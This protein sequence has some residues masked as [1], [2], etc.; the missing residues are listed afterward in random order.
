MGVHLLLCSSLLS[1]TLPSYFGNFILSPELFRVEKQ[2]TNE[3]MSSGKKQESIS[4]VSLASLKDP[5]PSSLACI[6]YSLML[7][8]TAPDQTLVRAFLLIV[9]LNWASTLAPALFWSA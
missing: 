4:G 6:I 1:R 5:S 7:T 2:A 8:K 3:K 9:L